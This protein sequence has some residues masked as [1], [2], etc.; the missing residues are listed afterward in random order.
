QRT[1]RFWWSPVY[2]VEDAEL[3]SSEA[4]RV[5]QPAHERVRLVEVTEIEEHARGERCVAEPAKAVVPVEI[6]ADAFRQRRGGR[7]DDRAGRREREELQGEQAA[8]DRIAVSA[9]VAASSDPPTPPRGGVLD[10]IPCITAE[11]G[12]H[13]GRLGVERQREHRALAT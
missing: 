12:E 13:C 7:G 8:H 2:V 11:R 6:P 9:R 4:R 1:L 10:A 5:E 3:G